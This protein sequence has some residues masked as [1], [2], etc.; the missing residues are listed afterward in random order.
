MMP[1]VCLNPS[2]QRWRQEDSHLR[3]LPQPLNVG[4]VGICLWKCRHVFSIWVCCSI[5]LIT[6]CTWQSKEWT[7]RQNCEWLTACELYILYISGIP[8]FC[9]S[10]INDYIFLFWKGIHSE[11]IL[12]FSLSLPHPLSLS[13][14]PSFPTLPLLKRIL[15]FASFLPGG[16]KHQLVENTMVLICFRVFSKMHPKV[17]YKHIKVKIESRLWHFQNSISVWSNFDMS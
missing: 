17:K 16:D 9:F 13:P 6:S 3:V 4:V 1:G 11:N 14:S 12:V 8:L 15:S 7:V 10:W 2:T 5:W